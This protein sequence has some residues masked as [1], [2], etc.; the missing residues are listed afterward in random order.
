MDLQRKS[1][2]AVFRFIIENNY[3]DDVITNE[4]S[5]DFL[6]DLFNNEYNKLGEAIME[7]YSHL[8]MPIVDWGGFMFNI[9]NLELTRTTYVNDGVIIGSISLEDGELNVDIDG[10][11]EDNEED[12][13][14]EDWEE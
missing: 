11:D 12:E 2:E 14:D 7:A 13:E 5:N 1:F 3:G 6:E 8:S 4:D 9:T 10:I